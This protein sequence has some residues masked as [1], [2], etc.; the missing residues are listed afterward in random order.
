M[1]PSFSWPISWP[2]YCGVTRRSKRTLFH[3]PTRT[4]RQRSRNG[5]LGSRGGPSVGVSCFHEP[6]VDTPKRSSTT[7]HPQ[8]SET[9]SLVSDRQCRRLHSRERFGD[10]V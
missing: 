10:R 3:P 7:T 8:A 4:K 6:P 5:C 1:W 9:C 2:S